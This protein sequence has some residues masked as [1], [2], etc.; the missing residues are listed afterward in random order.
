MPFTGWIA[1]VLSA[2]IGA[3]L[4]FDG[5]RALTIGDYVT[6]SSGRFAGQLGP[7]SKLIKAVGLDPR[8]TPVKLLHV[9]VGLGLV[10]SA[11]LLVTH[12]ALG[13]RCLL[14]AS[15]A[16]LWYLPFGTLALGVVIVLLM[17]PGVRAAALGG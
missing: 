16:G 14:V 5:G 9:V 17:L 3:W 11:V 10:V 7:W 8:G 12:P 15:I 13:W 1:S 2:F 4:A 6:P